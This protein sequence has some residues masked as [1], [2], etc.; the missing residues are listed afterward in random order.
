MS[1]APSFRFLLFVTVLAASPTFAD[2]ATAS[3][4]TD[5]AKVAR[6]A[7]ELLD[8]V[9][10][11]K[12]MLLRAE[13]FWKETTKEGLL[14]HLAYGPVSR[15]DAVLTR[16]YHPETGTEERERFVTVILRKDQALMDVAMDLAHELTHATTPPTWD[17]YDPKLTAGK[18]MHAA[19]EAPGGEIDAVFTE[20][21]VAVDFKRDLDLR[22]T[23]CDRYLILHGEENRLSVDRLKI[24]S[25]FYRIGKWDAFVRGKLGSDA[26]LF[27]LLSPKAPELY[28]ATGGAPYPVALMREYDELNRVACENVRKRV[29]NRTPAGAEDGRSL[30]DR[31]R[32]MSFSSVS[33]SP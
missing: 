23:R 28:S 31:C 26:I 10:S 27:P 24:Q 20:C 30:G 7:I 8:R 25:D 21:E 22:N 32:G 19:L 33:K 13:N 2:E 9:P 11:G 12:R 6:D 29:A 5:S 16:H 18:Y 3:K 1:G 15:T 4:T 14:K 17:P